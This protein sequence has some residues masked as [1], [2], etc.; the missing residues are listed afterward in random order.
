[1]DHGCG[2]QCWYLQCLFGIISFAL[3]WVKKKKAPLNRTERRNTSSLALYSLQNSI[4]CPVPWTR[5]LFQLWASQSQSISKAKKE[6]HTHSLSFYVC[7]IL[8]HIHCLVLISESLS[9]TSTS[10]L[11][12][13][14]CSFSFS[15]L[16]S[17]LFPSLFSLKLLHKKRVYQWKSKE[18]REM[19][20]WVFFVFT[21]Y[22]K[23]RN[24][25]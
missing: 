19:P 1:M 18:K 7:V 2:W 5:F 21:C 9:L 16:I 17:P 20:N 8:L 4:L 15:V 10:Q 6:K 25:D 24:A 11:V 12:V 13:P 23:N 3:F 14:L 22:I